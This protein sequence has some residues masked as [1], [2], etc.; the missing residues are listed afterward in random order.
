MKKLI[1]FIFAL[2]LLFILSGC[3][4]LEKEKSY[5]LTFECNGGTLISGKKPKS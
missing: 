5:L 3:D 1:L 4:L 2:L